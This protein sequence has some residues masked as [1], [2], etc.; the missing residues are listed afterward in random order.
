MTN[1][2][3]ASSIARE[4]AIMA[5]LAERGGTA[6]CRELAQDTFPRQV[7]D[8]RYFDY[9][10]TYQALKRLARDGRVR[11]E[12]IGVGCV[13]WIRTEPVVWLDESILEGEGKKP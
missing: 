2:R 6:T 5:A 12:P 4:D 13:I 11:S 9:P 10:S 8:R 7:P 3:H 1:R